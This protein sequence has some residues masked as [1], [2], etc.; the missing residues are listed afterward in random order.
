MVSTA[1][2]KKA[3]Q[4]LQEPP[5]GLRRIPFPFVAIVG[6]EKMK[7]ALILNA[8][9]PQIGGVLIRGERGTCKTVA[10]RGLSDVLPS[11]KV[12]CDCRFHCNP[13][14]PSEMCPDCQSRYFAGGGQPLKSVKRKMKV[15]DL[16]L[17]ST[18]DRVLGTI[19]LE[20]AIKKGERMLD[21]GI[22][23][24]ANRGITYIDEINLLDDHVIDALLDASSSK[25]NVVEREG[26][27]FSHPSNFILVGTMD[28]EEG[29]LRPQLLDRIALHVVV[30]SISNVDQ[31]VN[32]ITERNEFD[33]DP[34]AFASR[35][36]RKNTALRHRILK[37]KDILEKVDLPDKLLY[38]I[39]R[40]CKEVKAEGQRPDIMLSKTSKTLAAYDGRTVVNEDDI[41][42]AAEFILPFRVRATPFEEDNYADPNFM[43]DLID[44]FQDDISLDDSPG[45]G[46]GKERTDGDEM[47]EEIPTAVFRVGS[48]FE[49]PRD[50]VK[51]RSDKRIRSGSGDRIKSLSTGRKGRY[52]KHRIPDDVPQ[53]IAFDATIRAAAP[54]QKMRRESQTDKS[55]DFSVFI[56]NSDLRKKVREDKVS[57]L[58]VLTV[59][60]SG[61][62]GVM[63]RMEAT[64]GLVLSLLMDAYQRRDKV[65]VVA[66]R[67]KEAVVVLPPTSSVERARKMLDI[68]PTGGKTPLGSGLM[69][70]FN[71]IKVEKK[72]DP[73]LI[74]IL[75]LMTDGRANVSIVEGA[76]PMEEVEKMAAL[77][78]EERIF[79]IVVDTEVPP[80]AGAFVGFVYE[81]AEDIAKNLNG[82]YYKLKDLNAMSLGSLVHMEKSRM[83]GVG[84]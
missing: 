25:V 57:T 82:V 17:G 54:Y 34:V 64:K 44:Q 9:N 74:P 29:E 30:E 36:R 70:A 65:A 14:D 49:L 48:P 15:V 76:D 81:Y 39:S 35:Y 63:G 77:I 69:K 24:E 31:R 28:P 78:K 2:P 21:P 26:I 18:E 45:S 33:Q 3:K 42:K 37:A 62:M 8:I 68:L 55:R 22:L 32:I 67:G 51:R 80:S 5:P 11:I 83:L 1:E 46:S 60:A 50:L 27:S 6:Q 66:F 13:D 38:L 19:D 10:V 84:G 43:D 61:S 58:I 52:I 73:T 75:V 56:A 20:S 53:D 4:K 59:D 79:P 41:K 12:V 16:P 72:K 47:T 71:M 23:A 7:L 40:I